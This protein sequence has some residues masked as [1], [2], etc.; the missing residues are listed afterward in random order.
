MAKSLGIISLKGGVGKTSVVISL[1]SAL[2]QLGKKVLLVDG[3]LSSPSLGLHLNLVEPDKTLHHVLNRSCNINDAIY[4][5]ENIH[6]IPSS[7]FKEIN[8]TPLQLRNKLR[9]IKD[10]YDF[11]L[12][13][14]PPSLGEETIGVILAS[15]EIFVV[16]TP[17]HPTLGATLKAIKLIKKR[18]VPISGLILNKVYN[19]DFEISFEKIQECIGIPIL[20]AIP[21]DIHFI[22]SLYQ[23]KPYTLHKPNSKGSS[24]YKKLACA[25]CGQKYKRTGILDIFRKITPSKTDINREVFYTRVFKN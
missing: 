1:G 10:K 8:V 14:S 11:I 12:I 9:N 13:D 3:N 22:K 6:I 21:Y 19:K 16:T 2:A 7:L 20:A 24:E 15:D 25:L 4:E 5:Y 23:M 17:D 18:G